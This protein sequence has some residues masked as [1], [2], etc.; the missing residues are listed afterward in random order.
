MT[1]FL[2][3]KWQICY[4][5]QQTLQI[6][7]ANLNEIYNSH[8]NITCFSSESIL[9]FYAG[10]S[11]KKATEQFVSCIHIFC[12]LLS[13]SNL[14]NKNPTELGLEIQTALSR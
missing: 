1:N 8:A 13:V 9:H 5:S 7:T 4:S 12:K 14:A 6:S 2:T 3:W 10:S 11:I